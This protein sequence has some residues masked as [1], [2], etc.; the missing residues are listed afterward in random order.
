MVISVILK[1]LVDC[2]LKCIRTIEIHYVYPQQ[3]PKPKSDE[4]NPLKAP[5]DQETLSYSLT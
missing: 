5:H 2:P 3:K 4:H 1:T